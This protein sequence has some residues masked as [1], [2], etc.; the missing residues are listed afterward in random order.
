MKFSIERKEMQEAI[1]K[2]GK[3]IT[4]KL[5][6]PILDGMYIKASKEDNT[7]TLIGSD[8][9][10]TIKTVIGANVIDSGEVI[11]KP[12]ILGEIVR[13]LPDE[14][15]HFA[16]NEDG[17]LVEIKCFKS[18]YALVCNNGDEYPSTAIEN[19]VTDGV[20]LELEQGVLKDMVKSVQFAASDS[21]AR[22]VLK[23]IALKAKNGVLTLVAIDGYRLAKKTLELDTES[24]VS[25][26]IDA[27]LFNDISKLLKDN[28]EIVHL[29]I[30]RN[31][32]SFKFEDTVVILRLI[33][34]NFINY[35]SLIPSTESTLAVKVTRTDLIAAI[36]RVSVM[37]DNQNH[38]AKLDITS[39]L[40]VV[41]AKS[42]LGQVKED[43]QLSID[44]ENP[45]TIAFNAKYLLDALN[46]MG[47]D[48]VILNLISPVSP[49]LIKGVNDDTGEFLVL[50]VRMT[51]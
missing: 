41:S 49:C 39:G 35:E 32:V 27:K 43:I 47:N 38:L 30:G 15:M 51:R 18:E 33:D 19:T 4:E 23:G 8:G 1:A 10:M 29:S 17:Q 31:Q 46:A 44:V 22:P 3:A 25:A 37:S 12:R 21:D 20:H 2:V 14:E 11:I 24:E 48:E 34:G 45:L 6:N 9:D 26:I 36:N 50:P 40:M 5:G 28:D 42:Q 16:T 7:L 13:K